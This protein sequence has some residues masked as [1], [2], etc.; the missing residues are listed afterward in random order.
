MPWVEGKAAKL[1]RL[2]GNIK[3]AGLGVLCMSDLILLPKRLARKMEEEGT[4]W[5]DP[6]HPRTQKLLRH[7]IAESFEILP[8]LDG[9]IVRIG[10]TYLDDAPHHA[11]G[12]REKKN[13]E[14]TIIPLMQLLREELCV[15]RGK[16]LFFLTCPSTRIRKPMP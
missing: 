6:R 9:L 15:K 7:M 5:L 8:E 11:G 14:E 12:I 16:T 3:A 10:E 1:K 2:Y 13:P 4:D